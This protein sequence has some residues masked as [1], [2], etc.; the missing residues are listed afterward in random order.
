[1][2]YFLERYLEGQRSDVWDELVALGDRVREEPVF[3]D[4]VAVADET[5]RRVRNNAEILIPRLAAKGYQ[6]ADRT[7]EEKLR[8]VNRILSNI[9]AAKGRR[10]GQLAGKQQEKAALE[11]KLEKMRTRPIGN[12]LVF[13][14]LDEDTSY[15]DEQTA[16]YFHLIE[17]RVEGPMPI[18]LQAWYRRIGNISL[19]GSHEVLNPTGNPVADPL[20]VASLPH[21]YTTLCYANPGAK[22]RVALSADDRGKA[23]LPKTTPVGVSAIQY[24]I[25]I[26]NAA[27]DFLVENEWRGTYF[28]NYL[29]KA[30]EWGGFPGWERDPNPP[31]AA[32]AE[33]TEGLLPI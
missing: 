19:V 22:K 30:F 27:A 4:A 16:N 8:H 7:F 28:V 5:I 15:Q 2:A 23:G 24:M 6:F 13:E 21:F 20:A 32:I 18:S 26:P 3:A 11:A 25:S 14:A 1:M 17:Q 33:L 10:D 12:P 9:E 31:R 29:R